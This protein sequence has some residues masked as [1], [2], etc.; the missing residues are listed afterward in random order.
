MA[1]KRSTIPRIIGSP[2][3]ATRSVRYIPLGQGEAL[4]RAGKQ[5]QQAASGIADGAKALAGYLEDKIQLQEERNS[6]SFAK[7]YAEAEEEA[8]RRIQEEIRSKVGFD[9]EGSAARAAQIY[10]EVGEKYRPSMNGKYKDR[11]DALWGRL[12]SSQTRAISDFEMRNLRQAETKATESSLQAGI[13]RAGD[14]MD[15]EYQKQ[16]YEDL[17]ESYTRLYFLRNG[18][19]RDPRRV[20]EDIDKDME[21]GVLRTREGKTLRITDK[22]EGEGTVSRERADGIRSRWRVRAEAF[23]KGLTDIFDLAHGSVVDR[24]VKE[25]RTTEAKEYMARMTGEGIPLSEKTRSKLNAYIDNAEKVIVV[26]ALADS[27]VKE[28]ALEGGESRYGSAEQD[29]AYARHLERA[30]GD[31]EVLRLA[32]RKYAELRNLQELNLQGDVIRFAADNFW[33]SGPNGQKVPKPLSDRAVLIS[34]LP[35]GPL[36]DHFTKNLEKELK[37]YDDKVRG[38]PLFQIESAQQLSRF[39]EDVRKGYYQGGRDGSIQ[40]PLVSKE[41]I[42]ARLNAL[43]LSQEDKKRAVE[44]INDRGNAISLR[45]IT[46]VYAELIGRPLSAKDRDQYIPLLQRLLEDRRAGDALGTKAERARWIKENTVDILNLTVERKGAWYQVYD[47]KGTLLKNATAGEDISTLYL[48]GDRLEEFYSRQNT[49]RTLRGA[50]LRTDE[51]N[52]SSNRKSLR[53]QEDRRRYLYQPSKEAN[54]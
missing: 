9:T 39:K 34:K 42:A 14:S 27:I 46:G 10:K 2:R 50:K 36:K 1:D 33:L 48:Y 16:N 22:E 7:G 6:A 11:F 52:A 47:P 20:L 21:K 49:A 43:G 40:V 17:Q 28:A 41:Q 8:A 25:D 29:A 26:R 38:T 53:V 54:D 12:S 15:P 18:G 30:E 4:Q 24:L 45:E 32:K 35:S 31:S 13:R 51:E 44:Y 3:G 19:T 5:V 23:D 37:A